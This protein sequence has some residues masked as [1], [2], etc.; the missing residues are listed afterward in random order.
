MKR[1]RYFALAGTLALTAA[2]AVA[3][4]AA[5]A[6]EP[7]APAAQAGQQASSAGAER[8]RSAVLRRDVITREELEQTGTANL[9]DAVERLRPHWMRGRGGSNLGGGG[10]TIVVYQNDAQL[11]PLE[12]LRSLNLDFAEELRFLDSSQAS[13][14]L[15]GLGSRSVG[16]AIVILR[17]GTTR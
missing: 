7:S 12:A 1:I 5:H 6:Q 8:V 4:R 11:G 3:P 2:Y 17:P 13:N 14:M 10:H 9:Y 16:G 15:P